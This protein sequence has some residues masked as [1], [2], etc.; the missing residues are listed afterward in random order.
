[1]TF[2]NDVQGMSDV[3]RTDLRFRTDRK[4]RKKKAGYAQGLSAPNRT[5]ALWLQ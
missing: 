1:M 5:D 3:K 2:Q 4:V